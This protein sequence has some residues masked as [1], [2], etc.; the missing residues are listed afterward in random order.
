METAFLVH[1]LQLEDALE[2]GVNR[3]NNGL[4]DLI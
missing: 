1:D 2:A 3:A 4:G